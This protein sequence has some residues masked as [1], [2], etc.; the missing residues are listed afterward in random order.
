MLVLVLP[1]TAGPLR[2]SQGVAA[3][4]TLCRGQYDV[5]LN[6]GTHLRFGASNLAFRIEP[7][8]LGAPEAVLHVPIRHPDRGVIVF[9]SLEALKK[10]VK[11][12][13]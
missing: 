1:A 13:C 9:T 12:G 2:T 5:A 11:L 8:E 3:A 7:A 4:V 6:D 10:H